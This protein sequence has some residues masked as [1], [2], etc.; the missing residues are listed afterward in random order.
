MFLV[1]LSSRPKQIESVARDF[2]MRY[3]SWF[4]DC[5]FTKH[6]PLRSNEQQNEEG[7]QHGVRFLLLDEVFFLL[8]QVPTGKKKRNKHCSITSI[9]STKKSC[10][11]LQVIPLAWNNQSAKT[12]KDFL[13][14]RILQR[15]DPCD[16]VA[17]KS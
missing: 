14:A 7:G 15:S 2:E 12:D 16:S 9:Y 13:P 10:S 1:D 6:P 4:W 11:R 17:Y 8:G 3:Q 5:F